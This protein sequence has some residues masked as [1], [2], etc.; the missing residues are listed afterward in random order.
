MELGTA[1]MLGACLA[2]L[3]LWYT[4]SSALA[5]SRLRAF[6]GPA[7]ASFS[8]LYIARTAL[9]GRMWEVYRDAS[10]KYGPVVRIGPNELITDD[11][12]ILR[13]TSGAR[14]RYTRSSWYALNR[15]D[16]YEDSMFSLMSTSAHDKL[17]ARTAAAYGGKE[18][19]ALEMD[20]DSV[21]TAMVDKIRAKYISKPGVLVPLDLAKMAQYFTLDSITKI[22]FGEEFGFLANEKDMHGYLGIIEQVAPVMHLSAEVPALARLM[23][24]PLVLGL[25][26]PKTTDKNGMGKLMG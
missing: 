24:S 2:A 21:L 14:S 5:W 3:I 25:A 11:P 8:Y 13:R 6:N 15:L 17:K 12:E 9:S 23:S 26:G 18:N 16:P 10:A 7:L 20:V 22:A 1:Q 19:L 4:I